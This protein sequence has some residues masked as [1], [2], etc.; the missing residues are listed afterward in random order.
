MTQNIDESAEANNALVP[1]NSKQLQRGG[2][3]LDAAVRFA[4]FM[5][6]AKTVLPK[7]LHDAP[8]ECLAIVM[9]SRDWNMNPY[10]VGSKTSVINNRLMYEGQL[11]AGVIN[12]AR[13]LERRL[14]YEFAGE[15]K[16]RE[17]TAFG[18]IRGESEERSVTVG[19]PGPGEATNS[20]L[21]KG[22]PHQVDQQLTYKAARVWAR[23]YVPEIMLG[24]YTPED[25]WTQG[26]TASEANS[27]V[28]QGRVGILEGTPSNPEA[29]KV[30]EFTG[31]TINVDQGKPG[32]DM[33][34]QATVE[35]T[36]KGT[37]VLEVKTICGGC[38]GKGT[39]EDETGKGPCPDC[40]KAVTEGT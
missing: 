25:D 30:D 14:R 16:A 37:K 28:V 11:V 36:P 20:P 6:K 29:K 22:A 4:Q 38:G 10:M 35:V 34:A 2:D 21:W 33:T 13:V 12:N 24:V 8:G 27:A 26:A 15:G 19:V 23:R 5:A 32:G 3:E 17:C 31:V 1:Q 40:N 18:Q 39:V 7:H 9:I